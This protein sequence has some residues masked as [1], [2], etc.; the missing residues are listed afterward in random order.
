MDDA[1]S[2]LS[3]GELEPRGWVPENPRARATF[4]GILAR[5]ACGAIEMLM[6]AFEERYPTFKTR[7]QHVYEFLVSANKFRVKFGMSN[8]W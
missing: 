4:R 3:K 7:T 2:F 1:W 8:L 5:E 6:G